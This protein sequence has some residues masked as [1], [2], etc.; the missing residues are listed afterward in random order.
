LTFLPLPSTF[1]PYERTC[2]V[3]LATNIEKWLLIEVVNVRCPDWMWGC[4]AF[5]MAFIAAYPDFPRGNWPAWDSRIAMEGP[6]M[7][8]WMQRDN[9]CERVSEECGAD[10][11]HYMYTEL[12]REFQQLVSLYF[13]GP[14]IALTRSSD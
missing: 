5:W 12:W 9:Q 1:N 13:P 11:Y 8:R 7:E 3:T 14:L 2:W 4:N 6:F 10:T